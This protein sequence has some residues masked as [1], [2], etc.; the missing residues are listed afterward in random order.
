MM[1]S[2]AQ[3]D[4]KDNS[5]FLSIR[6]QAYRHLKQAVDEMRDCVQYVFWQNA[7]RFQGYISRY[8]KK[9]NNKA[10]SKPVETTAVG[11][12]G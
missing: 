11:H 6:D 4:R 12:A 3:V 2:T 8:H 1:L 5:R 10:R 9:F 7:E